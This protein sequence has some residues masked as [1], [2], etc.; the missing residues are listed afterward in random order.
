MLQF[1]ISII[2]FV[3]LFIFYDRIL[4]KY[5]SLSY[6]YRCLLVFLLS[7]PAL[8]INS[9]LFIFEIHFVLIYMILAIFIK[10]KKAIVIS[11]IASSLMMGYGYWNVKNIVRTEYQIDAP[12]S[13]QHDY[14]IT[15]ISDLHYPTTMNKKELENLVERISYEQSDMVICGGD[16]IDENTSTKKREEFFEIMSQLTRQCPV[17]YILGNHDLGKYSLTNSISIEE[18]ET[19]ACQNH[20]KI[21]QDQVIVQDDIVLIG[22][23]D[24]KNSHRKDIA[25][26]LPQKLSDRFVIVC[27][28][29]PKDLQSISSKNVDLHLSGHTHSGQIFPLYFIYELFGINEMNYGSE[30]YQHMMAINTSGVGGWGFPVRTQGHSEYVVI[31]I[32]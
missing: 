4:K 8:K 28:H 10:N 30:Y 15:F 3:F 1:S 27:D 32:K 22:R 24:V 5:T 26:L 29:Q 31:Q 21:L 25:E 19:L 12:Q 9:I 23:N 16:M 11:M 20:M 14:T 7:L 18:M 2:A 13:L 6:Y 17:Y